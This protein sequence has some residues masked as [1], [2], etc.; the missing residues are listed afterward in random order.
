MIRKTRGDYTPELKAKVAIEA[1]K[2]DKTLAELSSE[3][4][5]SV[6]T[7]MSWKREFLENSSLIFDRKNSEKRKEEELKEKDKHIDQLYK[8]VGQLTLQ[9][10]WAKKKI[11]QLGLDD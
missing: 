10:N 3:Y 4:D 6:N 1:L 8:E 2:E 11:K 5:V 9:V 7:I